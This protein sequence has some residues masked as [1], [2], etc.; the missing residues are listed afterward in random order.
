MIYY[1]DKVKGIWIANKTIQCNAGQLS[2]STGWILP[3]TASIH[4]ANQS[5]SDLSKE[6]IILSYKSHKFFSLS[7]FQRVVV[8]WNTLIWK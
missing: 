3:Q 8:S 2:V 5:K 6:S 7:M 1:R 4:K